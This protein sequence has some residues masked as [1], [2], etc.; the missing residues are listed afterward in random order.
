LQISQVFFKMQDREL[1]TLAYR[2]SYRR[3][4]ASNIEVSSNLIPLLSQPTQVGIPNFIYVRNRRDN[5]LES[6][7]GSYTTMEGGLASGHFGSAADFSRFVAK[8]STYHTFFRN[9]TTGQGFV[10]ARSTTVGIENPFGSTAVLD[11]AQKPL[12]GETLI[13][14]PERF[15][16][17]GGNS[18]RGFGLNQAGPRDPFTGFPVGGSALFLNSV[19]MRFPNVRMP[20]LNDQIGF[21]LFE[22]MGNVFARPQEML[23]SLVRFHQPDEDLCFKAAPPPF[24]SH[25]GYNY[26]SHAVGV[27]ARYQ[28]PI[29][30]LRFDFG[31]NLNPPYFPSYTN[32]TTNK[33]SGEQAGQFGYQ[34]APHFNFSFSVGQSF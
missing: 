20:Y 32:I 8:N 29:G 4:E 19:E 23:P 7:R 25:C 22:D 13:P 5:D 9:H 27:G 31:Y 16:S 3:V 30:P 21:T 28:T 24:Y 2:F 18:N 26:V 34:R 6:T 14:L 1:T 17:G 33:A 12:S 10:L 11:P 15:Y